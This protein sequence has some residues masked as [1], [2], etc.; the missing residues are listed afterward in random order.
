MAQQTIILPRVRMYWGDLFKPAADG[1]DEKTGRVFPG[2]YTFTGIFAP[3]SEAGKLAQSTFLKVAQEEFGPNFQA[4]VSAIDPKKRCIRNGDHKLDK[5]GN[6]IEGFGGMLYISAKNKARP[7]VIDS[8]FTN[9]K[10]TLILEDSGR[11]F[12]GCYVNAKVEISAYTSR[13]AEVGR[14]IG[15]KILAVQYVEEGPAF[16]SPPPTADGFEDMGGA[17]SLEGMDEAT[18]ALFG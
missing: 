17:P 1:K 12:R 11:I 16:G 4:I 6:V 10:P 9:G 15:A 2:Q 5:E 7:V 8:F 3:D 14:M 18:A 13:I